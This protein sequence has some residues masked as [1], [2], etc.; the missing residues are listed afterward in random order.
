M[1]LNQGR[2]GRSRMLQPETVALMNQ[3]QIGALPAGRMWSRIPEVT[4]DV[5]L[6]PGAE[7]RWGLGYMI[8]MAP[9]P[10]GRAAGTVG[11]AGLGNLYYWL[12]P[13][14]RV[15]GVIMT[16][17]LPFADPAALRLYGQFERAAYALA[18]A[19]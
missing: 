3:N 11:W 16:Q 19:S 12:D 1:L 7:L 10:N 17:I 5:D 18:D 2:L 4:N 14:R 9:G 6:F 15:A 13:A 8:N